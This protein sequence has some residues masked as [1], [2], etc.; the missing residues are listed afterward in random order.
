MLECTTVRRILREAEG[1]ALATPDRLDIDRHLLDCSECRAWQEAER[2]WRQALQE[3]LAEVET[4]LAVKEELF[5]A[6]AGAR[7]GL[8]LGRQRRRL[9][10]AIAGLGLLAT[11]L[12]ALWWWHEAS[13][14]SLLVAALTEDHLLYATRPTPAEFRS[15]EPEAVAAWLAGRVDF[16]VPVPPLSGAA[17]LGGRLCTIADRRAALWLYES[18]GRRVSL[19]QMSAERLALGRLRAMTRGGRLYRCGH[20]KG[21]SVLAW[22]ERGVLFALVSDLPEDDMLR[23]LRS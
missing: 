5:A 3:K 15:P 10:A 4:P 12:G 8:D 6:L 7:G 1:L 19:F 21:M 22:T 2:A 18:G 13:R 14:G 11:V 16:A 23:L 20:R 9:A 17:L